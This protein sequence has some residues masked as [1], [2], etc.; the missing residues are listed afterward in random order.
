M[1]IPCFVADSTCKPGYMKCANS[2]I[3]V[4]RRWL[5]DGDND[6]GDNSDEEPVFCRIT[7]C[8]PGELP[9]PLPY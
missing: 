4:S 1:D 7:S 2:G 8:A 3:C 5:C 9:S 6:C